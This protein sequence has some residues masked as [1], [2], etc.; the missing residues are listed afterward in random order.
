[1]R[2]YNFRKEAK[3]KEQQRRDF[4]WNNVG[5]WP[6]VPRRRIGEDNTQYYLEG[7]TGTYKPFLKKRANARVRQ[8]KGQIGNGAEYKRLYD[9]V[10]KW[11]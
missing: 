3:R 8:F 1:M 9:L 4:L 6:S 7:V 2:N 10:C 11:Y 5:Y